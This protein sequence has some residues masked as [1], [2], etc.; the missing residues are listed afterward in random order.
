MSLNVELV[1]NAMSE[2]DS[3]DELS[4]NYSDT[5]ADALFTSANWLHD[6]H[7]FLLFSTSYKMR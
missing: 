2:L 7:T 3:L 6:I 4:Q 5:K 1:K